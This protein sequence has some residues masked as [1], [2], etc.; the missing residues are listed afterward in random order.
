MAIVQ[1]YPRIDEP[2]KFAGF[3]DEKRLIPH[4]KTIEDGVLK[5]IIERSVEYAN[6]KSSRAILEIPDDAADEQVRAVY[7]KE[8]KSLLAYF[9]RYCGDPASTAYECEGRHYAEIAKEQFH[10]RTLQK[11]RMNSGWRYQRIA[12]QC[13]ETSH[14]F[15]SVS[16]IGAVEADFNITAETVDCPEIP[17]I[18]IYVSIKNRINTLGGQDWPKAIYALEDVARTD[19]NRSGPYLCVFGIAMERGQRTIKKN[20]KTKQPH[21]FNTE[22]WLSDFFWPFL[23][24]H[25]YEAIM[26][27]V[28]DFLA[29][30]GL[31]TENRTA[32]IPVPNELI[33]S[34]GK[35][36]RKNGLVD[37]DGKFNDRRKLVTFFCTKSVKIK[38]PK[39][40]KKSDE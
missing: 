21:S 5:K 22:V 1:K 24:N 37:A 14:R 26:L 38:K 31:T 23:A 15:K 33:E 16:D 35:E 7:L 8:G 6:K 27:A 10:N 20:S 3:L 30:Q 36:C 34:F 28:S 40:K 2:D 25:S 19:K 12:Y 17:I 32:G 11:E 4:K 13:A 9:R 39:G 29:E 18:N